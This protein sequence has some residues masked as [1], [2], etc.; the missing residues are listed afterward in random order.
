MENVQI[1]KNRSNLKLISRDV[2]LDLF[3]DNA[4]NFADFK[5]SN[6]DLSVIGSNIIIKNKTTGFELILKEAFNFKY[7]VLNTIYSLFK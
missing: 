5:K 4:L 3:K 6:F 2:S 1:I 7:K